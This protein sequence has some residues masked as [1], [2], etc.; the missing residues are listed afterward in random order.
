MDVSSLLQIVLAHFGSAGAVGKI[1]SISALLLMGL[2]TLITA[3]VALWHSVVAVIMAL[4]VLVPSLSK[5]ANAMSA[6]QAKIDDKSSKLLA[7]MNRISAILPPV[8]K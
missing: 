6:D 8:K 4:A 2:P 7:L 1:I 5:L 3:M